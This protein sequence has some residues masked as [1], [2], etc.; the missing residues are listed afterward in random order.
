M[1]RLL[2]L[3]SAISPQRLVSLGLLLLLLTAGCGG[4]DGDVERSEVSGSV[5]Y[6][7]KPIEDGQIRFVPEE[8]TVGPVSA[9]PIAN[10]KYTIDAKG[11]V[12]VGAHRVEIEA[13]Q[14]DEKAGSEE[15]PGVEGPPRKQYIPAKY[16]QKT[17]LKADVDDSGQVT[18][19][20][21]LSK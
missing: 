13:Y 17:E 4:S 5:T 21:E 19:D 9:A 2:R 20:F 12:P 7:G 16:N 6:A 3:P 14:V 1:P 11:G 15:I 8:G 10:G 18:K